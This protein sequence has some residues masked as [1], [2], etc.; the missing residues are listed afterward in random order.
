MLEKEQFGFNAFWW[1]H[2]H[3]DEEVRMCV[4]C[5]A[6]IGYRHVE[7]SDGRLA[8]RQEAG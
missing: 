8:L 3:S 2:L 4:A 6:E 1:G 7:V 5:L